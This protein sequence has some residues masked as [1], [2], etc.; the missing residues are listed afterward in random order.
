MLSLG[1]WG[2]CSTPA[3]RPL[4]WQRGSTRPCAPEPD[5]LIGEVEKIPE[6][7]GG[8]AAHPIFGKQILRFDFG[9]SLISGP[10]VRFHVAQRPETSGDVCLGNPAL[11]E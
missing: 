4:L 7:Y 9:G 3:F 8:L 6:R 1:G 11:F 5:R 10:V 2:A